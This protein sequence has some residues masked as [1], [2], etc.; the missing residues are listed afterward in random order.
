VRR[1]VAERLDT[2]PRA[3]TF[4]LGGSVSHRGESL[5]SLTV[6]CATDG[7][8]GRAVAW[9]ARQVGCQCVIYIHAGVSE[10]RAAAL[11]QLGA[12]VVR[13]PGN[14]DAS[15][16]VAAERAHER[17]CILV[18]DTA[19]HSGNS[20]PLYVM[21]GYTVLMREIGEQLAREAPPTHL[22]VQAGVGGLAAAVIAG[23]CAA[24][25]SRRPRAIV[26]EPESADCVFRS[27]VNQR[28]T[29]VPGALATVMAGLACGEVSPGAWPLL[30]AAVDDVMTVPDE[31]IAPTMQLLFRGVT[32]DRPLVIGESGVAGATAA[33]VARRDA[34][35]A[36]ALALS[37]ASRVLVFGTEGATDP[38]VYR[39]LVPD[40][41][42][43]EAL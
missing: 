40:Y 41:D 1:L 14:Y 26:V 38:V 21:A 10:V 9:G 23:A 7:N 5:R 28:A 36:S 43:D 13:V 30:Q 33:I 6:T 35:L 39:Q 25:G 3:V 19:A 15:V 29:P 32:G 16:R 8:H 4:P 24:W 37:A 42:G 18:A 34:Q 27:I 11:R 20:S 2:D 17:G 12:E 22:F 31:L